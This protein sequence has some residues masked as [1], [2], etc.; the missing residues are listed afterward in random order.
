MTD[1]FR[2]PPRGLV[3]GSF[4]LLLALAAQ[5]TAR[6]VWTHALAPGAAV[7]VRDDGTVAILAGDAQLLDVSAGLTPSRF[8]RGSDDL[9][10]TARK[11]EGDEGGRRGFSSRAD[12]D[13]DGRIDEDP[14]D[15]RDDDGDGRVDE[16][17]AAIGDDMAVVAFRRGERALHLET[18]HW[19]YPHL[20]NTVFAAWRRTDV[21]GAPQS[22][23]LALSLPEGEWQ[24]LKVGWDD[25]PGAAD[26][27][28]MV[29][30]VP[31]DGG[32]W[33]IGVGLPGASFEGAG[34]R[35]E[36][37]RLEVPFEGE[38]V[39]AISVTP[40]LTQ[41]RQRQA[42]AHAV[43]AGAPA[44]PDRPVVPWLVTPLQHC[45][46]AAE[47]LAATWDR[48]EAGWRL[49]LEIP[50]ENRAL[51]DPETLSCDDHPLGAPVR[52]DW[53]PTTADREG[54]R[55]ERSAPWPRPA[56][57]EL[58]RVDADPHPYRTDGRMTGGVLTFHFEDP[59]RLADEAR[60]ICET[61]CG[62][63]I[64]IEAAAVARPVAPSPA[65][66]I[67]PADPAAKIARD[68]ERR[69][70]TLSPGLL[71]TYPNPFR[72]FT[73]LRYTVPATIGE[74]F[75]REEDEELPLKDSDPVPY[76]SGTPSVSL[77]VYTVAGHEVVTFF[78]GI[79]SI[80]TYETSWDGT[81]RM[82]RPVA[83]GTYFCK[84]QIDNWSVTK[85][86]ALLR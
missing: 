20:R 32:R 15:G 5:A 72:Q 6:P 83:V 8:W 30:S 18:Y 63:G 76:S 2:S 13:D 62:Q 44:G 41:L 66:E 16:D 42:V 7:E 40:T 35:I 1:P 73:R 19:N 69:P 27:P 86:V 84:L 59:P 68:L 70:P 71:D 61:V 49:D 9:V 47:P 77:R 80:G 55:P 25:P 56:P 39:V 57:G 74:A 45:P 17:F 65:G 21:E 82:G 85:R 12:D 52:V 53:R 3:M 54:V 10:F 36:D 51:P 58:W 43:H 33:W 29:A 37:G 46:Y 81:D 22:D 60:L 64:L 78:D 23:R 79:C 4:L 26:R 48:E 24:E 11:R 75:V 28:M 14:L 31:R 67:D 50:D 34:P 38:L